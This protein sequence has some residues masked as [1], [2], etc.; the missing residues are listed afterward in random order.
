MKH[1]NEEFSEENAWRITRDFNP[2]EKA[3]KKKRMESAS[4]R[5]FPKAI[6]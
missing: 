1:F 2:D 5:V 6:L 3:G 4:R